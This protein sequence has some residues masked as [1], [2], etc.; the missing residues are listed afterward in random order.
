MFDGFS[1]GIPGG[2]GMEF[3]LHNFARDHWF[4]YSLKEDIGRSIFD[5]ASRKIET[6][7]YL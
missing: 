2:E 6:V 4:R 5:L 3:G 7:G 1:D